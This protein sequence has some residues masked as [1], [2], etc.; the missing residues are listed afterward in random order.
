MQEY[1]KSVVAE[2]EKC[3]KLNDVN[4]KNVEKLNIHIN[5]VEYMINALLHH[6]QKI[7]E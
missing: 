3:K 6:I 5:Q 7:T 2:I 4:L 1:F